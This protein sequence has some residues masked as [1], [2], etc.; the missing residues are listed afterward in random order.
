MRFMREGGERERDR[1]TD[2]ELN[3]I[4]RERMYNST[5]ELKA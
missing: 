4:Q 1:Q 2:K 5:S 3:G